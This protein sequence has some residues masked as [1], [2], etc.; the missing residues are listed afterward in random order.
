MTPDVSLAA[1]REAAA[2]AT[3]GLF[4]RYAA[5]LKL[6][7]KIRRT[8]QKLLALFS[9]GKLFG[10]VHTCIGQEFIAVAVGRAVQQDDVIFSNHRG[11]GHF[12]ATGGTITELI[13][14]VMGKEAGVCRGRGGSQH[15]QKGRYFSNGIQGGIVPVTAGLALAQKLKG[16]GAIAVVFV[17]D[18]TLGEGA[19]Y[20]TFN[21]ASKWDLPLLIVC[22]NNLFAQSTSQC[23]TL[24]GDIC[25]RAEAFG[26]PTRHGTTYNWPQLLADVERSVADVRSSGRPL[27]HRIDT[28]RLMA[29]SKGDDNRPAE[30]VQEHWARDPLSIVETTLADDPRLAEV[31]REI[32]TEIAEATATAE[33]SG[34]SAV[35]L[36]TTTSD[37]T[38]W[39]PLDFEPEKVVASVRRGLETA[40]SADDRVILIGEDIESPYGGAFKCTAELSAKFPGRVRNTPISELAIVGMANGLALGGM[41]A[42]VEIMFG[43]F[44]TL[45]LDQWVNHAGKFG[46]MFADKV[47]VPMIL[48]TPMGGKRG[49]GATHSQS[50]ERLLVGVPGTQVLC[51]HHRYLPASLYE[52]LFGSIDRP[53]VVVENK[54]LYGKTASASPPPGYELLASEDHFPVVRLQPTVSPDITIV[55]VGATT[56]DVEEAVATLFEEDEVT[57]DVFMPTRL[58]PFDVGCLLDSL[59]TT[60]R[61]LVVEEGQGFAGIG[62]E[63]IA[64]AVRKIGPSGIACERVYAAPVPIPAARPLESECLP[65]PA[66][67]LAKARRLLDSRSGTEDNP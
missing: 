26:I 55:A 66:A 32:D 62:A 37:S 41:I 36:P 5:E 48:R 3:A 45:A 51:L 8:E 56:L 35:R 12:L 44:V 11:H 54:L 19:L 7:L 9:E 16:T 47:T 14:E 28:F 21:I 4:D 64:E 59:R 34:F 50:L 60:R 65:G 61:L 25:A 58:Y 42:V 43:D 46:Y 63:I 52:T 38:T 13:A 33:A 57:A 20:E 67:I 17:G 22:E 1:M 29:H 31:A 24:A 23:Q 6:A 18:G 49:Y 40:L 15:L 27:F 39:R 53:T 30:Y 2:G 10:T